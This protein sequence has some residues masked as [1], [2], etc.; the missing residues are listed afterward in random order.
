MTGQDAGPAVRLLARL[1]EHREFARTV[2]GDRY[3]VEVEK[4]WRIVE[5]R[6]TREGRGTLPVAFD[7]FR[8]ADE[9]GAG[10]AAA[11]FT[12]SIVEGSEGAFGETRGG[13]GETNPTAGETTGGTRP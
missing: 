1:Y 11:L 2:F 8:E 13:K 4:A 7:L 9:K 3:R 10:V 5:A 6:A 12:A